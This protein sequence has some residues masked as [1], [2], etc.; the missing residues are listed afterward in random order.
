M[1][2]EI[3]VLYEKKKKKDLHEMLTMTPKQQH[4]HNNNNV[5]VNKHR[6]PLE[7]VLNDGNLNF[8]GTSIG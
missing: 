7:D 6:A 8:W 1:K 4:Q 5:F 3:E 2:Q